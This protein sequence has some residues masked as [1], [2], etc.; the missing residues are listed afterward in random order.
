MALYSGIREAFARFKSEL[1]SIAPVIDFD[2]PSD[3]TNVRANFADPV[4]VTADVNAVL[5][6]EIW[7]S[8]STGWAQHYDP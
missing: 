6:R 4:H 8:D 2:F 7:G 3:L 5:A 1:A